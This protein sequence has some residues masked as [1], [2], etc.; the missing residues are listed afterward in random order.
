MKLFRKITL[1]NGKRIIYFCG[2]KVWSY[3]KPIGEPDFKYDILK[4]MAIKKCDNLQNLVL[5]SSHGRDC[6]IPSKYDFN[7]S[8]SSL[9]MY[10]IWKLYEYVVKHNADNLRKIIIVW[11]VFHAGLQLEK[12]KEYAR[13][14]PY[15]ALYGID[16]AL[17]LPENDG[18][19]IEILNRQTKEVICPTGFRG[20]A[21]YKL[22]HF[23]EPTAVLVAKH[24]KNTKRNNHQINYL[25]KI[26]DLA[27]K[28]GHKMYVVL[29]PYRK[30]Y[31]GCLPNEIEIYHELFDFLDKNK[32]VKLLNFQHDEDFEY[33]DFDSP[34]HCNE[35]GG[36]KMT[37]KINKAINKNGNKQ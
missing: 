34:D 18:F 32:N 3:Y 30:D 5:G 14:I 15:K 24:V 31:L 33:D 27:Q 11:S 21:T 35:C 8:A 26:A 9:D 20:K 4:Y 10:R 23:D 17:P 28:S 13:C 12:T 19:A 16:Y 1:I 7:L 6:F 2:I 29:P 22:N 36:I 37:E 25:Q